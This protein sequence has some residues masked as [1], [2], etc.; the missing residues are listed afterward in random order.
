MAFAAARRRG[1]A[2]AASTRPFWLRMAIICAAFAVLRSVDA[3]MAVSAAFRAFAHSMGERPGPIL[4]VIAAVAFG[5]AVVGLLLFRGKSLHPS[6]R[7]AAI[8][9]ILLVLL[10]MAQSVSLYRPVVFLQESIGPVT[11]SRIIESV[12]LII[13]AGCAAWF[14]RDANSGEA[15]QLPE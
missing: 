3:N 8:A 13:L 7:G 15:V 9:I 14:I 1:P 4:M 12:L 5:A 2:V 6:V 10:A 11:V